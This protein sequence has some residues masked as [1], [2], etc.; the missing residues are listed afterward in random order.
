QEVFVIHCVK[1][2]RQVPLL[3]MV[4]ADNAPGLVLAFAERGQKQARQNRD[5]RDDNQQLNQSESQF[6]SRFP[7]HE[8]GAYWNPRSCQC[9]L[10][11]RSS[12]TLQCH[13]A[14]NI[15]TSPV[16]GLAHEPANWPPASDRPFALPSENLLRAPGKCRKTSGG[17]G[18]P[19]GTTSFVLAP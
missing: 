18:P 15:F 10:I 13:P 12:S 19:A 11:H 9:S 4:Q 16:P 17:C 1:V 8:P 7:G 5:D 3:E 6:P 2:R 14:S